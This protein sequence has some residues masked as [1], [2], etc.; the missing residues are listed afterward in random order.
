M[1]YIPAILQLFASRSRPVQLP[2]SPDE[3]L[4]AST[5]PQP[6][7]PA[8]SRDPLH[9]PAV[10]LG[11]ARVSLVLQAISF[12]FIATSKDAG[13]FV[14]GGAL[15]ALA[16]GYYPTMHS[17]SLELYTRRGGAS[18]EAGRLFGATS[19]IQ[20]IGCASS[21]QFATLTEYL[22]IVTQ[23][24]G[25]RTV[26]FRHC[27]HQ[28]GCH[29]PRGDV[30]C[31]DSRS[32]TIAAFSLPRADTSRFRSRGYRGGGSSSHRCACDCCG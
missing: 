11:I 28:D 15:S 1:Y 31:C 4:N 19:V 27:V 6:E 12:A 20:T 29:V 24:P 3:P 16:A 14:A 7:P 21:T 13:Q 18:S 22:D 26:T 10:D 32:F 17:L 23:E 25:R 8:P 30:L 9:V 5:S 2:T